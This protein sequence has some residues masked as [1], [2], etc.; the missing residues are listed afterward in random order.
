M[1]FCYNMFAYIDGDFLEKAV[2]VLQP[3]DGKAA[4]KEAVKAGAMRP[5][6]AKRG[7][8][9]SVFDGRYKFVR[10]FSPKQH[11]RPDSLEALVKL[12]DVE[13]FDLQTDPLEGG[14]RGRGPDAARW[15]GRWLG[16]DGRR[17]RRVSSIIDTAPV[18]P[19]HRPCSK[20]PVPA[21]SADVQGS[22][23]PVPER[24]PSEFI[25][26]I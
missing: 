20:T 12:N 14:R 4:L 1:L 6:L 22:P 11:N 17:E 24:C 13:L 9:R 19:F 2:R 25:D 23:G 7:A 15:R 16:R 21:S 18:S 5:D 26:T 10:Y 3:P 8:I